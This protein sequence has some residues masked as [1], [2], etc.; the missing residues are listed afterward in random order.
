MTT[1]VQATSPSLLSPFK[2]YQLDSA[3]DE[4]FESSRAYRSHYRA[5]CERILELP[6]VELKRGQ[7]ATD[8]SCLRRGMFLGAPQKAS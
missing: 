3:F 2:D 7:Q 4:M 8:L 5:L 1:R 6:A